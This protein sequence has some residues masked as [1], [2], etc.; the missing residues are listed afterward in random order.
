MSSARSLPATTA[1]ARP[2][3]QV[4]P[5]TVTGDD[6]SPVRARLARILAGRDFPALSQQIA[7]TIS[8][9][10]DNASSMQRLTNLLR[11]R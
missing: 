2:E 11:K 4:R 6:S 3:P 1:S 9:L 7:D 5:A 10:D 8:A